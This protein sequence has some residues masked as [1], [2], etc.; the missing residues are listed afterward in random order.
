METPL[1]PHRGR[2]RPATGRTTMTVRIPTALKPVVDAMLAAW[3]HSQGTPLKTER[4][5]TQGAAP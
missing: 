5:S 1:K 4:R 2:G 3:N